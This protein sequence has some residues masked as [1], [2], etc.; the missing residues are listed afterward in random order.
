[1]SREEYFCKGGLGHLLCLR[2]E[3]RDL[4][5]CYPV[6]GRQPLPQKYSNP[7]STQRSLRWWVG[8]ECGLTGERQPERC[9]PTIPLPTP[10]TQQEAWTESPCCNP[11]CMFLLHINQHFSNL[12]VHRITWEIYDNT[13]SDLGGLCIFISNK[14][15][16]L[17]VDVPYFEK[18]WS[19]L[20]PHFHSKQQALG[21]PSG[22]GLLCPLWGGCV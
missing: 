7:L 5:S 17:S 11:V 20:Y 16:M 22:P 3:A 10:P 15:M 6:Q 21:Y 18:P 1:M 9:P 13:D 8:L 4:R 2:A 12:D 14:Q 19:K